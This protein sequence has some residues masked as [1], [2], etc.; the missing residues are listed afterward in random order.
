MAQMQTTLAVRKAECLRHGIP[1]GL[2]MLET[3]QLPRMC[4]PC[5]QT[6]HTH[7]ACT[8]TE[9]VS[10]RLLD[11]T[12]TGVRLQRSGFFQRPG[13]W[14]AIPTVHWPSPWAGRYTRATC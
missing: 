11:E 8:N 7:N 3:A 1:R 9:T 6:V 5:Q 10:G 2:H 14:A 4:K 12:K 13:C